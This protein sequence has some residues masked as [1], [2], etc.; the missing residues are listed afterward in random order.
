MLVL[1]RKVEED[2]VIGSSITI[3]VLGISAG[4]VR[5]GIQAPRNI[6]VHRGEIAEAIRRDLE[7]QQGEDHAG[8]DD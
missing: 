1:T 4:S 2:V 7:A 6:S 8:T 5:L 3:V